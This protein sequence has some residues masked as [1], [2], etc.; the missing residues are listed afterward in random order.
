ML[1]DDVVNEFELLSRY[2]VPFQPYT[3]EKGMNFVWV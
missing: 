3:S 2:F 1:D